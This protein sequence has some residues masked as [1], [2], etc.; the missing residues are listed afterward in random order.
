[1]KKYWDKSYKFIQKKKFK[2]IPFLLPYPKFFFLIIKLNGIYV[3]F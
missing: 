1:M 3:V 2:I